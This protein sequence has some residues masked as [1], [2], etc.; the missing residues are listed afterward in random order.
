MHDESTNFLK[1]PKPIRESPKEDPRALQINPPLTVAGGVQ[2]VVSSLTHITHEMG[3]M[4]GGKALLTVNQ[5]GGFDCPGC[6]WPDPDDDRA[7]T[8]FCE[9]GV[10][11]VAHEA[12]RKAI[13]RQFFQRWSIDALGRQSDY[14]LNQQG[15]L[16]HPMIK[17]AGATHYRPITWEEAFTKMAS[18]LNA[19][20]DSN[21]AIF[22]TSGRTSNEAAFL[23][24]LFVRLY[25]TNNLPDSSNMCHESSSVALKEVI[26]IGK[27]TVTLDDF[28]HC[29]A[30][31]I[32]GQN[33]GTNHPRMLATL[34]KAARRGCQIVSINPLPEAGTIRFIH[35][36]EFTAWMGEGTPLSALFLPVKVN[37]D[38]PLLKGFMKDLLEREDQQPGT[39]L[40]M[41]FIRQ[42]THGFEALAKAL[43][44]VSWDNIV[45]GSGIP[46]E[47]IQKAVNIVINAKN[48]ICTWAMGMTQHKNAVANMQEII[49][50]LLLRGNIGRQGAGPCPVRGHSNVQGNRTMGITE[51]PSPDFL[52]SLG[53]IFDFEPP[54]QRGHDAV[55]GIKAMHEGKAKVFI[56]LGGNFLSAT[57]DTAYTAEALSRCR[58]TVHISTKLNRAHL[59]TGEEALILPA[60]GRTDQDSQSGNLQYVTVENT[61]GIIQTSKG[62]LQPISRDIRSEVN[63]VGNLAKAT[64]T[65]RSGPG[66]QID[67]DKLINNYDEIRSLISQTIS[68]FENYSGRAQH[69]GGFYLP[70]PVR[71]S[72]TFLTPTNKATFTVHPLPKIVLESGQLLMTTIRSHDQ[73]NTTIYGLDDRYRG[74]KAGRRVV[75]MNQTDMD[76]RGL[77]KGDLVDIASHYEGETRRAEQFTVVPYPIPRTCVATYFPE[78]NILIPIDSVADKSNTPTS[79]SVVVT[80]HTRS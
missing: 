79:K 55:R 68:G 42:H 8:E 73:F 67:W 66:Q 27:A 35:P 78:A 9:N 20:E 59:V 63:I 41:P 64:F 39:M 26:G 40:D 58:L 52:H 24:Q 21:E 70:N 15:R 32:F 38:V 25:G 46:R 5:N 17:E 45:E 31:F 77:A 74:V 37:G 76:E 1:A 60:L 14:W 18:H 75:F 43:R 6:A 3:L 72:R 80:I 22:Y 16:T 10:K 4:R 54:I 53:K 61:M 57:P 29:D 56:A 33:P 11:S 65:K 28:E 50:F 51:N 12:T 36:K 7:V 19:L 13:T 34:Q 30:I 69:P 48:I 62:P 2:A 47:D 23:Y 44:E 49:N 71:D